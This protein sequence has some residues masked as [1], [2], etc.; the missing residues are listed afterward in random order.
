VG[1]SGI[2]FSGFWQASVGLFFQNISLYYFKKVLFIS[3]SYQK[4]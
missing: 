1:L 2:P 3:L 4:A